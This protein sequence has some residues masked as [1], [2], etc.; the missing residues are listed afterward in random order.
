MLKLLSVLGI[1]WLWDRFRM[2]LDISNIFSVAQQIN[3]TDEELIRK[4]KKGEKELFAQIVERYSQKMYKYM[5]HYFNF[6][7]A[8]AEDIVQDIFVK[9]REKLGKYNSQQKFSSWL[10]RF[11]HNYTIDWI[12]KHKKDESVQA[13]SHVLW[14]RD[15][16]WHNFA[17]NFVVS[18]VDILDTM[19][20][21]IKSEVLKHLLEG[22]DDKYKDVVLLFYFE[23][24]SYDEIAYILD[25]KPDHVGTLL[26]RAKKKIKKIV[27][28]DPQLKEMIDFDL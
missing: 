1:V 18:D 14:D 10:Y 23:Q 28:S 27:E 2:S 15:E 12:R 7:G 9:L 25:I 6:Q 22:L 17:D 8:I 5:Y 16:K 4:I 3:F 26:L 21:D 20:H 19:H 11:A 13:F 24:M